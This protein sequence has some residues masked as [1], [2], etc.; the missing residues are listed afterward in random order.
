M[1]N[2]KNNKSGLLAIKMLQNKGFEA[3]FVGGCVR[4]YIMGLEAKDFDIT[5]SAMP[6][7]IVDVFV[8]KN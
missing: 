1:S 5:T 3:G 4:D 8:E 2:I 7:V 6:N